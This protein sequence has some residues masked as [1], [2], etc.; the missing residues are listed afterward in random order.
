MISLNASSNRPFL[1]YK[2][3]ALVAYIRVQPTFEVNYDSGM[4]HN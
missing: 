2:E 1:N 3:A 4:S